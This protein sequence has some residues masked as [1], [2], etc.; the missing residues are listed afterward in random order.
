MYV[1]TCVFE[2]CV[3]TNSKTYEEADVMHR[4]TYTYA[5]MIIIVCI[6]TYRELRE[7]IVRS[8]LMQSKS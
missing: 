8:I 6:Y 3:Q 1:G 4:N 2:V 5:S 7:R